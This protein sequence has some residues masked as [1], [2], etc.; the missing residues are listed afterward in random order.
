M[1]SKIRLS[2]YFLFFVMLASACIAYDGPTEEG[3]F[4]PIGW[5][6]EGDIFAFGYYTGQ[7]AMRDASQM[8]VVI[9]N[10]VT[11]SILFQFKRDWWATSIGDDSD[12]QVPSPQNAWNQIATIVN[13]QLAFYNIKEGT[14][15]LK[16]FP[17]PDAFNA[18]IRHFDEGPGY[19]MYIKLAD[20]REKMITIYDESLS[21]Y[22]DS[23]IQGFVRNPDKKRI[24]VIVM[25]WIERFEEFQAVGCH[26]KFGFK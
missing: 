8:V 21:G 16:T 19:G 14:Y 24:A 13:E 9:Q 4:F 26:M 2:Q 18:E 17:H 3:G 12:V 25:F 22:K 20:G 23:M 15:T 7:E 6:A 10:M 5:S 11:D 1:Q